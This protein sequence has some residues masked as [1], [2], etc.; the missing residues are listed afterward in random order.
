MP[1]PPESS[2]VSRNIKSIW[3]TDYDKAIGDVT[4]YLDSGSGYSQY[5]EH[6][7]IEAP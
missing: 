2:A 1:L 6:L 3:I 4:G 7:A 5:K